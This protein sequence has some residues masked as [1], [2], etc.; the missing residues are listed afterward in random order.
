MNE[1]CFIGSSMS[2]KVHTNSKTTR[3]FPRYWRVAT[4]QSFRTRR[5]TTPRCPNYR[6]VVL[7]FVW[8]K[9]CADLNLWAIN[10]KFSQILEN[11]VTYNLQSDW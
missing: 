11:Y 9:F 10:L 5:F 4:P 6:R 7:L 1:C 3:R 2:L 8:R